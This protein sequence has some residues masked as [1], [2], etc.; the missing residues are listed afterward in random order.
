MPERR[1]ARDEAGHGPR[2]AT[3]RTG[4]RRLARTG[5]LFAL[6]LALSILEN[7]LFPLGAVLP[8]PGAK[9]GLANLAVLAALELDGLGTAAAVSLL[10]VISAGLLLGALGAPAFWLSLG[11]ALAGLAGMWMAR[12]LPGISVIGVSIAGA[13]CHNLGQLASLALVIPGAT[14]FFLVPWL[15]LLG[16][17]AG[18]IT[19]WLAAGIVGRLR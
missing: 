12:H 16:I 1:A 9:L 10:R 14:A 4:A 17:P 13:V 8:V 15:I 3:G 11:G 19:G 5:A 6:A 7:T 18:S 2:P